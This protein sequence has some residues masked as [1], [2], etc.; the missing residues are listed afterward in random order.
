MKHVKLY[1]AFSTS[2]FLT[3]DQIKWLDRCAKGRWKMNPSTGL[4][5]VDGGFY[6]PEQGLTDFKGVAFGHISGSSGS[7]YCDNNLL[8]SLVG[9]P[10]SVDGMFYCENNR[11]T[12]LVGAPQTVGEMFSCNNNRLTSLEGAPRIVGRG[13]YCRNNLLTSLKGAPQTVRIFYCENNPVS[14]ET[15]ASIFALMKKGKSYQQ[16]LGE[17][18]PEMGNEDRALMYKQMPNLPPEEVRKYQALATVSRIKGYL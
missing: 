4:I 18:W 1:E 11:L 17:H 8:T 13:F 9:A 6:C 15:L 2:T 10:Q 3:E 5:D 16:A 14:K 7:F 12:S